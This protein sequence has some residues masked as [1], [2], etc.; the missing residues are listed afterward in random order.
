MIDEVQYA[1][2]LFSTIK[3]VVDK[4]KT[5]GQFWLT[6][7]QKFALMREITESLA[8]RVGIL[9]LMGLSQSKIRNQGQHSRPFLPTIDWIDHARQNPPGPFALGKLYE[10]IW[11]GSFPRLWQDK[12]VSCDIF[13]RSYIQTYIQ[14]DVRDL[15]Q[16][17]DDTAFS[18]FLRVLAARTGRLL[19]FSDIARDVDINHKTAKAW[20]SI[21]ETSGLVYLLQPYYSNLTKRLVKTPKLYFL[22]KGLCSY[23]TRWDSPQSLE[24]GALA[25]A[26]FETYLVAEILKSYWHH[27]LSAPLFF[28]RDSDQKDVDLLIESDDTLY[29]VECKKSANPSS[30]FRKG[31]NPQA[32]QVLNKLG[33]KIGPGAI[34]CLIEKDMPISREVMAIPVG[35]LG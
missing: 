10:Q 7:S 20:L 4:N 1:P 32:F 18:R 33:R 22:D 21:L 3:S 12:K 28:Y 24:A 11:R 30:A 26:I 5:M 23:I 29:S 31:Q 35:Y 15:L 8:G 34:V 25:G 27:G 19:N 9:D 17:S 13:Y 14:R 16:I 6:G 2:E